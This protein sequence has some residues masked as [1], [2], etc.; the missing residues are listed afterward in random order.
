MRERGMNEDVDYE[1]WDDAPDEID[2]VEI[3][4]MLYES[5]IK[6]FRLEVLQ[7]MCLRELKD[8][9]LSKVDAPTA[10]PQSRE[11]PDGPDDPSACRGVRQV[12]LGESR[13]G[14]WIKLDG[15]RTSAGTWT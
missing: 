12:T 7:R 11:P 4:E 8:V 9:G 6:P 14:A 3:R 5:G 15:P 13:K 10:Y 1:P 2:P